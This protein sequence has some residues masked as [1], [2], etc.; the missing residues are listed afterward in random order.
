[1]KLNPDNR[2]PEEKEAEL[3]EEERQASEQFD[4]EYQL[5]VENLKFKCLDSDELVD[6]AHDALH[7][8]DSHKYA[9]FAELEITKGQ[10][11]K[12]FGFD[13][14]EEYR[15]GVDLD[16]VWGEARLILVS[17]MNAD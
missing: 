14:D 10:L 12:L 1:M 8:R 6:I 2:T 4:K 7:A 11:Y 3:V 15:D 13:K 17:V 16:P 5:P 9:T